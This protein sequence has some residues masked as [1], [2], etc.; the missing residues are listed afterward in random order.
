MTHQPKYLD[1]L[2]TRDPQPRERDLM[3]RLP[4]LIAHAQKANGW[5]FI[6]SG[7]SAADINSRAALAQLPV[8]R[9]SE[10]KDLQKL[11]SP[12]GGLTT[13]PVRQLGRPVVSP[14]PSFDP[15][16]RAQGRERFA[17]PLH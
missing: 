3:A 7:V 17:Q 11:D 9:K 13:T 14:W 8:T 6:L 10:L 1:P 15:E 12:F 2:K 4:Q 5:A 16:G